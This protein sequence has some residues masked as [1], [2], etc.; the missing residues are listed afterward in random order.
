MS[1]SMAGK[2]L[3]CGYPLAGT[4]MNLE[5]VAFYDERIEVLKIERDAL[6]SVLLDVQQDCVAAN[7]RI[8]ALEAFVAACDALEQGLV[9]TAAPGYSGPSVLDLIEEKDRAR[10]ALKEAGE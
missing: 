6:A 1:D 10:D 2:C 9:S 7:A 4:P 5:V 3:T 8:E